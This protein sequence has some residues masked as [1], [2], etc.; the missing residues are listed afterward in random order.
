MALFG[1]DEPVGVARTLSAGRLTVTLQDG[2]LR[3]VCIG[4]REAIRAISCV[5]RDPEW[6]T[7]APRIS[8]L[9]VE[10]A[11]GFLVRYDALCSADG[12]EYRYRVRIE[13]RPD[14]IL[15]RMTG[16]AMTD[17]R[18]ARLG[19]VVLHPIEGVS[20]CPVHVLH[21]DGREEETSF[22][23]LI[24]PYQP[25]MDI[26]ALTH[27]VMPGVR[28][29]C[30]MEGDAF[31]MEDQ[32]NWTDASYKTY[33]RPIGLPWPYLIPRGE[34]SEQGVAL[35]VTGEVADEAA[36][37][38][39]VRLQV[40]GVAG[41]MPSLGLQLDPDI[42]LSAPELALLRELGPAHLLV[43]CGPGEPDRLQAAQA[44]ADATGAALHLEAVLPGLHLDE[45]ATALADAV[46]EADLHPSRILVAPA[47]DLKGTLP[48]SPWPDCPP[49][50]QVYRAMRDAFPG[51]ALGGGSYCFFTELNRKRPPLALLDVVTF[52]TGAIVHAA[53]DTSVMETLAC[54]PAVFASARAIAGDRAVHVGPSGIGCRDN[55][56]GV[57]AT[58]NPGNVRRA[59]TDRDPRQ[60]GLFAASWTAG[61]LARCAE[62]GVEAVT[63]GAAVGA[64]GAIHR[65]ASPSGAPALYPVYHVLRAAA[66]ASGRPMREVRSS[67]PDR[68]L[69]L[70]WDDAGGTGLLVANLTPV[71]QGVAIEGP[72]GWHYRT[73]LDLE[74]SQ[75]AAVQP[76]FLHP[77]TP[78]AVDDH[79]ELEP[80]AVCWLCEG[81]AEPPGR[82]VG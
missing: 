44:V 72:H 14:G 33:V 70:A 17:F 41:T 39:P 73:V 5:V 1:S 15:F 23:A 32:R 67:Q 76:N 38:G 68:V 57:A 69:A 6:G 81:N 82:G 64:F 36:P 24:E 55:P 74:R 71:R 25:I 65:E 13:G 2:N 18:T 35:T 80:Y 49:L 27:E 53:D 16:E 19:F 51:V 37:D 4:G 46:R 59:M 43:R 62:A 9:V 54:L 50:E 21:T 58:A 20:G 61:Y 31:E 45:E 60:R 22:P 79:L 7:Y 34:V 30:R 40:G 29:T 47:A 26:R 42:T 66:A 12:Q 63:L 75:A 52:P 48:G 8:A 78:H 11:D 28:V 56:Y 77:A 3:H 10:K